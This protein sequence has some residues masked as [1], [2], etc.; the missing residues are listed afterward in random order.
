MNSKY[1]KIDAKLEK[2]ASV[3]PFYVT[4]SGKPE[5]YSFKTQIFTNLLKIYLVS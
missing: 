2:G 5:L 1:F 4:D 3:T